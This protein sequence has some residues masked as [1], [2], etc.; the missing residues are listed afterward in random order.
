MK[1]TVGD[2]PTH[3]VGA[4]CMLKQVSKLC[5][6]LALLDPRFSVLPL[7]GMPTQ[8][9]SWPGTCSGSAAVP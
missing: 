5:I 1:R 7:Q 9:P 6:V 2:P 8:K 3:H 4:K